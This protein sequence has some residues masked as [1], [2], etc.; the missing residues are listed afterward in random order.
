MFVLASLIGIFSYLIFV[1]GVSGLLYKNII[2]SVTLIYWGSILGYFFYTKK[3][4]NLKFKNNF[5]NLSVLSKIL[6]LLIILQAFVNLIG[7]LGPELS[8]DSLWYHL[9]LPKIFLENNRIFHISGGLLYYSDIPK[10]IEMLFAVSLAFGNEVLAKLVHFVFGLLTMLTIFKISRK[11][12][13]IE[14]SL[15]SCIIFYSSLLVGWESITA[16]VDLGTAFFTAVSVYLFINWLDKK[17]NKYLLYTALIT[18]LTIATKTISLNLIFIFAALI[19]IFGVKEKFSFKKIIFQLISF[20][21]ISVITALPWFIFA[22][23][24]TGNPL[25]PLFDPNIT[26]INTVSLLP[27]LNMFIFSQD[28]INPIY[29]ILLPLIIVYFLR[30]DFKLRMLSLFTLFALIFWV[31]DSEIGGARFFLPYLPSLSVISV[32]AVNNIKY[33]KFKNYLI[34]LVVIISLISIGY[35]FVA[36]VKYLPVI[37]GRESKSQFLTTHLNFSFGDFYDTDN[38]FKTHIKQTDK[39]LLYGFHNLYY[40]NFPFIDSSFAEGGDRFNYIAVL[41]GNILPR[42]QNWRKIYYNNLTK[43]SLYSLGG[44]QWVY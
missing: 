19:I 32:A 24:N 18:G 3:K 44:K 26:I 10:N 33:L 42:F 17:N 8:F 31:L 28:P 7:A 14:L 12:F 22:F 2:I 4:N 30:F 15:L 23:A 27:L 13:N 5:K 38:Y 11:F 35:R 9:T 6:L 39:V 20:I 34:I 21:F 40:V 36:N 1:L 29:A 41:D 37:L 43:V 16:Y 25:Y